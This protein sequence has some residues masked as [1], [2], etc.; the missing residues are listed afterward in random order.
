MAGLD[1]TH[2]QSV[3]VWGGGG[4]R[5]WA[6]KGWGGCGGGWEV[7]GISATMTVG[8]T[9]RRNTLMWQRAQWWI[10]GR[11]TWNGEREKNVKL[12]DVSLG[13]GSYTRKRDEW[14]QENKKSHSGSLKK[15]KGRKRNREYREKHQRSKKQWLRKWVSRGWLSQSSTGKKYLKLYSLLR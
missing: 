2:S 12:M 6:Q 1:H 4:L 13:N 8:K 15:K 5:E 9:V 11:E 10:D 7:G 3:C 14:M